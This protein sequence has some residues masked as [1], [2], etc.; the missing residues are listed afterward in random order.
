MT[1]ILVKLKFLT[2]TLDA[3]SFIEFNDQAF[4]SADQDWTAY[5]SKLIGVMF[6][7]TLYQ[8][9]KF[10]TGRNWKHLQMTK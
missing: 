5:M 9:T 2:K 3:F 7:L 10:W 1:L 8:M 4:E 6:G